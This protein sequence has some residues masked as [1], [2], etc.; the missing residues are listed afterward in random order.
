MI[1]GGESDISVMGVWMELIPILMDDF[2]ASETSGESLR[3]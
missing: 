3:M 1:S 2:E